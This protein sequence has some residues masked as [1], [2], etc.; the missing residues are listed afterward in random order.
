MLL[1]GQA[2][3]DTGRVRVRRDHITTGLAEDEGAVRGSGD[4]EEIEAGKHCVDSILSK[5]E[6]TE[7]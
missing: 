5:L 4:S 6:S 2:V 7:K 3:V 1:V